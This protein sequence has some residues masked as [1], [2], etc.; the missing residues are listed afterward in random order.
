MFTRKK[1]NNHI[2]R[3]RYY[4]AG[5][6]HSE[7]YFRRTPSPHRRMPSVESSGTLK[8]GG[9]GQVSTS[10]FQSP[11]VQRVSREESG[12]ATPNRSSTGGSSH[13]SFASLIPEHPSPATSTPL[14]APESRQGSSGGDV[15][16]FSIGGDTMA[17]P[18]RS[19]TADSAGN[20][21]RSQT[22]IFLRKYSRVMVTPSVARVSFNSERR[23][24][25]ENNSD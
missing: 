6:R 14:S 20:I 19:A 25:Q 5:N 24:E 4:S 17:I 21:G 15:F 8:R 9:V 7:L 22:P 23:Q 10:A 16:K 3:S 2:P 18:Q 13:G 1:I 11:A 12:M